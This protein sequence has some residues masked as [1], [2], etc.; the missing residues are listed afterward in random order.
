MGIILSFQGEPGYRNREVRPGDILLKVDGV[1]VADRPV[2]EV[3]SALHGAH[4]TIVEMQLRPAAPLTGSAPQ[5]AP[6]IIRARRHTPD[7]SLIADRLRGGIRRLG[8]GNVS[9][10]IGDD[11]LPA[12]CVGFESAQRTGDKSFKAIFK[13]LQVRDS[14]FLHAQSLFC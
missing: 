6:Y 12:E 13:E 8:G 3:R 14:F 1:D 4:D 10:S 5:G 7:S 11:L 2:V 9:A